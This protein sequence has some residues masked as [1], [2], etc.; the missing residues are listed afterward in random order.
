MRVIQV[1]MSE[2]LWP[3][4]KRRKLRWPSARHACDAPA[5][6]WGWGSAG[7]A[8]ELARDLPSA[9]LMNRVPCADF[10][11]WMQFAPA[12]FFYSNWQRS[13]GCSCIDCS[14]TLQLAELTEVPS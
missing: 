14:N 4:K 3:P 8:G 10:D 7:A 2:M 9:G 5:S 6:L 12:G 13:K 1:P 11:Y